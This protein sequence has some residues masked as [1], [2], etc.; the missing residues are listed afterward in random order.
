MKE[1]NLSRKRTFFNKTFFLDKLIEENNN[2]NVI[3]FK[4]NGE[5]YALKLK[6]TKAYYEKLKKDDNQNFQSLIYKTLVPITT[7]NYK[8][9]IEKIKSFQSNRYPILIND[10]HFTVLENVEI[11]LSPELYARN[12]SFLRSFTETGEVN[13]TSTMLNRFNRNLN[14][15]NY[16]VSKIYSFEKESPTPMVRNLSD[17]NFSVSITSQ[18]VMK[19]DDFVLPDFKIDIKIK[20]PTS[21]SEIFKK[22]LEFSYSILEAKT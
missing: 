11:Y 19:K 20:K 18:K 6:I 8:F 15:Q 2:K 5:I 9:L 16:S 1:E 21:A 13:V 7:T 22:T 14:D 17:Q 3:F 12:K 4:Y 10:D